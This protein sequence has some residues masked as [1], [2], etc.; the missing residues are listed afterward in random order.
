[1]SSFK[2][3]ERC[4][5]LRES[6]AE[7][8]QRRSAPTALFVHVPAFEIIAL[9]QQMQFVRDLVR[10]LTQ[11]RALPAQPRPVSGKGFPTPEEENSRFARKRTSS[12]IC[13]VQ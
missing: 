6:V 5:K 11:P 9:E 8:A 4:L 7:E 3:L 2:S 13:I 12:S 1:M 10:R